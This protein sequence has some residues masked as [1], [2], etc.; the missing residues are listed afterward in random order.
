MNVRRV[1]ILLYKELVQGPKSF[2]FI[3][4]LG[5]PVAV[6]LVIS[7]VFGTFFTGQ[8]R[9]GVVDAGDSQLIP[10]AQANQ[11]VRVETFASAAELEDA[12]RRGAIDMGVVLP[13]EFDA[14]VAAS[15]LVNV[16]VYVWGESQLQ[17]RMILG[18]ALVQI[19]RQIAGQEV[20][21]EIVETVLGQGANIPWQQRLLPLIVLLAVM[22]SGIMVPA[23]S[24]VTEKVN[25]TLSA[26]AVTPTTLWE[27]FVA[28][29]LLGILLSVFTGTLI[30]FLNQAFGG[31][32]ALLLSVLFL[33]A[34]FSAVLGVLLGAWVKDINTLFATIK[35]IGIVLYAPGIVYLFPEIPQWIGRIFPTY[36]IVQPVLEISQFNAGL[37]DVALDLGI[38]VG[39]IVVGMLVVARVAVR[40]REAVAAT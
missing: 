18:T 24:L 21:V 4:A 34:T 17:N 31:H 22:I 2:I 12:T 25:H 20:P 16:T 39:L 27:V 1:F 8:S 6:S 40:T 7:L 11:A 19:M 15:D 26:V 28:K 14:R 35:S 3:M 13:S 37:S 29:G 10:L 30:L 38:L 9:L 33:G 32:P 36:Y 23:A 5:M